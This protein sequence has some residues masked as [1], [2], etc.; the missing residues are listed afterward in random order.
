MG[1]FKYTSTM[2]SMIA[3]MIAA[4]ALAAPDVAWESIGHFKLNK[5]AFPNISQFGDSEKF[6]LCSSFKAFGSGSVYVVPDITEAVQAGDVSTL[7][8]VKLDTHSF[9]F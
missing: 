9:E 4:V 1:N 8:P 2:K 7:E 3:S 6:L 5:A